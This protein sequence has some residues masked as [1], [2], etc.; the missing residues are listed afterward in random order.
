MSQS[1]DTRSAAV[2]V[3]RVVGAA[4]LGTT[5]G[6]HAYLYSIGY[7]SIPT[8][9]PL[10]MAN[11]VV[12]SLLM[13]SVLG[14]PRRWLLLP[15]VGGVLL[16]AGTALA[17]VV[18]QQRGLFGFQESTQATL[19]WPSFYVET[20]GAVVFLALSVTLGLHAYRKSADARLHGAEAAARPNA[21]R[22]GS[23]SPT[24]AER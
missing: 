21:Q 15:A 16:E 10:F 18:T 1:R 23:L 6:I 11:I 3:A 4:L 2:P 17:L 8:I 22:S 5:A 20:A 14:S 9:G 19:F 24:D 12:G 7:S 13:L